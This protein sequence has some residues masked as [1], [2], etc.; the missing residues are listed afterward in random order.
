[1]GFVKSEGRNV[2]AGDSTSMVMDS[3][4][5][6]TLPLMFTLL[7]FVVRIHGIPS[8]IKSEIHD[9]PASNKWLV[10]LGWIFPP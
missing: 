7:S 6:L 4:V 1:M 9:S 8:V 2:T 5:M 10:F 3:W